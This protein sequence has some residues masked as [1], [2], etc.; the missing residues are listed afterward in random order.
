MQ[1]LWQRAKEQIERQT[2]TKD[3]TAWIEPV[4]FL[5]NNGDTLT[6][7][8]PN[9]FVRKW[10]NDHYLQTISDKLSELA[11]RRVEAKLE[12][13]EQ[14]THGQMDFGKTIL[15]KEKTEPTVKSKRKSETNRQG[16]NPKYT[17]SGFI[18]G[19]SNQFARAACLSVAKKPGKAFNPLFLYGGVGLGKTHLINAIANYALDKNPS[20][21]VVA[22]SAERFMN[23][24][25]NSIHHNR[26]NGFRNKYRGCDVL[27]IDDIHFL[28]GKERTQE[29]FFHTFN[30][31]HDSGGQIVITSDRYPKDIPDLEDR[32]RSRFAWGLVADIQP[33]ELET[34]MAILREKA[35]QDQVELPDDV[36]FFLASKFVDNVRELEGAFVRLSA[37]CSLNG[38][39]IEMAMAKRVLR[40]LIGDPDRMVTI[41]MVQKSVCDYFKVRLNDLRSAR[42]QKIIAV[43]R[44]IGMYLSRRLTDSSFPNIG[45][46][47]GGRDHSTVI[48]ACKKIELLKTKDPSME[49]T[50]ETLEKTIKA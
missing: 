8:A 40:S 2:E 38:N 18:E 23:E 15:G 16:V 30:S 10:V 41:D 46:Q 17:F 27:L 26:V 39:K 48:H 14:P 33:P 3:Y 7:E 28:A 44:Q 6:L 4:R 22:L 24:M 35:E 34:R 5:S 45:Q 9:N 31:L 1:D 12:V 13:A 21:R 42:R 50:L 36:A 29:E 11:G 37:F 20:I 25:I 43:P 49:T 32:L 47:F 19:P